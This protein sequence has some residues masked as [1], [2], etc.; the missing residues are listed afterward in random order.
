MF[1][2]VLM[3]AEQECLDECRWG[4]LPH[5]SEESHYCIPF[6]EES[7]YERLPTLKFENS[8]RIFLICIFWRCVTEND[9]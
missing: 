3:Y 7:T 5:Q 8:N 4:C 2:G 6:T 9:K 1:R